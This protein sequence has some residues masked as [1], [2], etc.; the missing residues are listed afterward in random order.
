MQP[1]G[2]TV[3]GVQAYLNVHKDQ[4]EVVPLLHARLDQIIRFLAVF[5]YCHVCTFC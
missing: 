4:I 5:G 2:A 3:N 1:K